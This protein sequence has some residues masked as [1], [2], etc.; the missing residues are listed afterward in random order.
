MDE[1]TVIVAANLVKALN[2]D[3][4]SLGY[5]TLPSSILPEPS[6][7]VVLSFL[8][9]LHSV[10]QDLE[11][12]R[13]ALDASQSQSSRLRNDH[14]ASLAK[15]DRS[16][17]EV[18][19]MERLVEE[20]RAKS[21]RAEAK[22]KELEAKCKSLEGELRRFRKNEIGAARAVSRKSPGP[23]APV[24][25]CPRC[26][27]PRTINK[28]THKRSCE[29]CASGDRNGPTA[30]W[31]AMFDEKIKDIIGG[32]EIGTEDGLED[33]EDDGSNSKELIS[34]LWARLQELEGERSAAPSP[35]GVSKSGGSSKGPPSN[36]KPSLRQTKN[37]ANRSGSPARDPTRPRRTS[38]SSITSAT[39]NTSS[40]P[41]AST[42][43]TRTRT[44][45][46]A[47]P[48]PAKPTKAKS[49]PLPAKLTS[50]PSTLSISPT[51]KPRTSSQSPENS[52]DGSNEALTD[53]AR[54]QLIAELE[55]SAQIIEQ[56]LLQPDDIPLTPIVPPTPR[57]SS[58]P[59]I[60]D[61]MTFR[62]DY[63]P[64]VT[65]AVLSMQD[66]EREKKTSELLEYIDSLIGVPPT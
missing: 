47:S 53:D 60:P 35:N 37:T 13:A 51:P 50:R 61:R 52:L 1:E 21:N 57:K 38:T 33:G 19:R 39:S 2:R 30:D 45:R 18:E 41:P 32:S 27:R 62:T 58:V 48:S 42:F 44:P 65:A 15:A 36:A 49:A 9:L 24:H 66:Q 7:R 25:P 3:L 29:N 26:N 28:I 43:T 34:V 8:E 5:N 12:S 56:L 31:G 10:S 16:K 23:P 6:P 40:H 22:C 4:S 55:E 11:S 20:I 64:S 54:I 14:A 59:L 17:K 46:T 63:V